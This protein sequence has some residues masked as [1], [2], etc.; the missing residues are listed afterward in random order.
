MKPLLYQGVYA[1]S[2]NIKCM[3]KSMQFLF[4]MSILLEGQSSF[5]GTN[6]TILDKPILNAPT[7]SPA[8]GQQVVLVT[9]LDPEG[10]PIEGAS[11]NAPC[12]HLSPQITDAEGVATF[13]L[14][15]SCNC[16]AQ[17]AYI[18]GTGCSAEI[19]LQCTSSNDAIC[20]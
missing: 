4:A 10:K 7:I 6:G 15:G 9:V 13:D 20:K 8:R 18:T 16:N 11:V 2:L 3:K 19:G 17:P 14:P 5:A 1:V 12:T